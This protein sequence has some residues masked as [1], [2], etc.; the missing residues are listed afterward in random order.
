MSEGGVPQRGI[1]EQLFIATRVSDGKNSVFYRNDNQCTDLGIIITGNTNRVR[2]S[3]N[4]DPFR[5]ND[6]FAVYNGTTGPLLVTVYRLSR[7]GAV[8]RVY[9]LNS[10]ISAQLERTYTFAALGGSPGAVSTTY[11]FMTSFGLFTPSAAVTTLTWQGNS[12]G[13]LYSGAFN[14]VTLALSP[15]W[16]RADEVLPPGLTF[17]LAQMR[18]TWGLPSFRC[19]D[20][21]GHLIVSVGVTIAPAGPLAADPAVPPR[22]LTSNILMDVTN[23]DTL[24]PIALQGT[25]PRADSNGAVMTHQH[26]ATRVRSLGVSL[27]LVRETTTAYPAADVATVKIVGRNAHFVNGFTLFS[28]GQLAANGIG[29][30]SVCPHFVLY[31]QDSSLKI[32]HLGTDTIKT[33]IATDLDSQSPSTAEDAIGIARCT[34]YV[35]KALF[36]WLLWASGDAVLRSFL[37]T[38]NNF[39]EYGSPAPDAP[40][41]FDEATLPVVFGPLADAGGMQRLNL[42]FVSG[43]ANF[44]WDEQVVLDNLQQPWDE[45]LWEWLW[46]DSMVMGDGGFDCHRAVILCHPDTPVHP[47]A[48]FIAKFPGGGQVAHP[49]KLTGSGRISSNVF[50]SEPEHYEDEPVLVYTIE[51][52]T[53]LML[54]R[55]L[56]STGDDLFITRMRT[57]LQPVPEDSAYRLEAIEPFLRR[58]AGVHPGTREITAAPIWSN[59]LDEPT[60]TAGT[61][62]LVPGLNDASQPVRAPVGVIQTARWVGHQLYGLNTNCVF[63]YLGAILRGRGLD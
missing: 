6:Y 17:G 14:T 4:R 28:G 8:D 5:A 10:D 22:I 36:P 51:G 21:R 37:N 59:I 45:W 40:L 48:A 12:I 26:M 13:V 58:G 57:G 49:M 33:V 60:G 34:N 9:P 52:A 35:F 63:R 7:L 50:T 15:L 43:T 62:V 29:V 53:K 55:E 39:I 44:G 41:T 1:V 23:G 16:H 20:E 19:L 18:V 31:R 27:A 42:P 47:P 25:L 30:Y 11:A 3:S 32:G 61:G 2:W 46:D 54:P 24:E 38:S 56:Q